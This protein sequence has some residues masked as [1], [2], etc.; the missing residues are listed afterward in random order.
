MKKAMLIFLLAFAGIGTGCGNKHKKAP[1]NNVDGRMVRSG[2][3]GGQTLTDIAL[4]GGIYMHNESQD[5]FQWNVQGFVNSVIPEEYLG[6]V[7]GDYYSNDSRTGIVFGGRVVPQNG[8]I[9]QAGAQGGRVT[10][11]PSSR[12]LVFVYDEFVG[13]KDGSGQDIPPIPMHLTS[14][15]GYVEGA[16]GYFKFWDARGS[17]TFSGEFRSDGLFVADVDY[18]NQVRY[19]GEGSGAEGTLGRAIIQ[20]CSFVQCN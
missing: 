18:D 13:Q 11:A 2:G 7:N 6:F 12:L 19:D 5:S 1:I 16:R 3:A 15:S 14:A 9:T 4:N 8:R 10:I 17:I 20:T